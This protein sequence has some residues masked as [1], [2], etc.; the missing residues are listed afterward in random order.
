[1]HPVT[2]SPPPSATRDEAF[3]RLYRNACFEARFSLAICL[4]AT[5]W[6]VTYCY[7]RG[8]THPPDSWLV[9][10]GLAV[11]RSPDTMQTILGFPDWVFIGIILPW[12][13]CTLIT[14]FFAQFIMADDDLGP[15]AQEGGRHESHS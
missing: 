5:A 9:K 10:A 3:A 7:L 14:L 1:M 2:D 13:L 8:Y 6:T 11:S 12:F 15:E 4:L